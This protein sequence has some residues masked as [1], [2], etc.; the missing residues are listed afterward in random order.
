MRN[1]KE[2]IIIDA[3]HKFHNLNMRANSTEKCNFSILNKEKNT[4]SE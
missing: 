3:A 4:I 2:D 1:K